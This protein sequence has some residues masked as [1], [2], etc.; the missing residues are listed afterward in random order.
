MNPSR[1]TRPFIDILTELSLTASLK[2]C[3]D[4][5][6][7][8]SYTSGQKWLDLAGLGYD[9]M[10]GSETSSSSTGDEPTFNGTT[11]GLTASEYWSFDGGDFF[12]YDSVNEAWMNAIHQNLSTFSTSFLY[13]HT[14]STPLIYVAG[15][16]TSG[17]DIGF[18]ISMNVT[19]ANS[20]SFVVMKGSGGAD[21]NLISTGDLN[22]GAWNIVT[23]SYDEPAGGTASFI[24]INGTVTNFDG[25]MT[26]PSSANATYTMEIGARGNA[27]DPFTNNTRL[28]LISMWS[29]ALSEANAES[30]RTNIAPRFGL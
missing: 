16:A 10:L 24:N 19:T 3:L 4:A 21:V 14:S 8:N 27:A 18:V 25:S 11:G 28:G 13:Y 30:I 22:V 17:S 26:S 15:T 6:D 1:F 9:F 5:G 2:L 23:I 20:V 7:A 12:R 29:A